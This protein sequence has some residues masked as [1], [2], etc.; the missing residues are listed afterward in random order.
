MF[1]K[2]SPG[3]WPTIMTIPIVLILLSL[4]VWQIN[5]YFWKVELLDTLATQLA[6]EPTE[7]PSGDLNADE[8]NYRRVFMNGTFDYSKEAHL[9]AHAEKGRK[10]FH[11]IS[12]FTRSDT[13]EVI[14]VNRGF[15]PERLKE[16]EKRAQGNIEGEVRISGV[17]RQP[18]EKAYSF[19]P[20]S[21]AKTNVWLYGELKEMAAHMQ[22]DA[23]PVF[24]E[25][26]DMKLPGIFPLG[27][28]TRISVPNNH[29]QYAITWFSLAVAMLVI[30]GL[31]AVKRGSAKE[32]E[33]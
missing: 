20:E 16:A 17:V 14:L 7:M 3:L 10:G 13:G 31:Y 11:I 2:F 30:F 1:K 6:A 28:Q 25:L 33:S 24:V 4:S 19:L 8:W 15:V 29:I 32:Q 26:D 12:P 18:W 21:N 5:R 27:G 22:V 23:A 9:F